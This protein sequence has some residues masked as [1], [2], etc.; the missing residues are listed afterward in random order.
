MRFNTAWLPVSVFFFACC[1]LSDGATAT[2]RCS[3][4]RAPPANVIAACSAVIATDRAAGWALVNRGLAY[5]RV[6]REVDAIADY[7]SA[8]AVDPNDLLAL[9][10][11]GK[12]FSRRGDHELAIGDFTHALLAFPGDANTQRDRAATF[13]RMLK[14]SEALSDLS[15]AIDQFPFDASL[16]N[17]RAWTYLEARKLDTRAHIFESQGNNIRALQDFLRAIELNPKS[18]SARN[19]LQRLKSD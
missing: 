2:S 11:R 6:G 5:A 15:S 1:G 10:N 7:T 9:R 17:D 4:W 3:D 8:I 12:L 14:F 18:T 13:R 16:R 19:G